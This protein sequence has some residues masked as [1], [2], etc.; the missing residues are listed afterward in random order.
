MRVRLLIALLLLGGAFSQK[1]TASVSPNLERY[2][3]SHFPSC[4]WIIDHENRY[5]DPTLDYGGGHGDVGQSYGI[6]Q[7]TPGTKMESAGRDWRTNP[8]TQWRWMRSY[9]LSRYEDHGDC[10]NAKAHK[11]LYGSY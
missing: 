2:V 7:A 4:A 6:A 10:V 5:W 11:V 1:S 8:W 3:R 9:V